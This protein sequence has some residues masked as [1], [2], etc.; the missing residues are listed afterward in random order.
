[1]FTPAGGKPVPL[2]LATWN[3]YGTAQRVG[4][5][6]P[7][8]YVDGGIHTNQLSATGANCFIHPQWTDNAAS[9]QQNNWQLHSTQYPTP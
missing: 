5:N 2:K 6:V 4:T 8:I 1:M 3:W 7:A 9:M